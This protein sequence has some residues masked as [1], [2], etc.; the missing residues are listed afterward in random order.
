MWLFNLLNEITEN[1]LQKILNEAAL[2][3]YLTQSAA[4]NGIS[5]SLGFLLFKTETKTFLSSETLAVDL[6]TGG[7]LPGIVLSALTECKWFLLD[8]K[9]RRSEFLQWAVKELELTRKVTVIEEDAANFAHS[10]YRHKASLVTARSFAVPGVTAECAAPLLISGGYLVVSEPPH[11]VDRWPVSGL[12][13]LGLKKDAHWEHNSAS[14]QSLIL[15]DVIEGKFPRKFSS[16]EKSPL[17]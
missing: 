3:G 8:R 15:N 10:N 7:G 6:G 16:I 11:S 9:K 1:K 13:K 17:F 5:H 4:D 12:D 2:E 14:F